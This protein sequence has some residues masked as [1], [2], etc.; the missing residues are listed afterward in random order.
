M[1][2]DPKKRSCPEP[3]DSLMDRSRDRAKRWATKEPS[4]NKIV[5]VRIPNDE[6]SN[7]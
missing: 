2:C 6:E 4:G 5:N 3:S 1:K 7:E